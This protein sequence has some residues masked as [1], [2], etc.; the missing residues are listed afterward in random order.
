MSVNYT[1]KMLIRVLQVFIPQTE[2]TGRTHTNKEAGERE[3]GRTYGPTNVDDSNKWG[4]QP[5]STNATRTSVRRVSTIERRTG[6]TKTST[7]ST[8]RWG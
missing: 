2:E 1:A 7:I 6:T 4:R 5:T 3:G 8:S